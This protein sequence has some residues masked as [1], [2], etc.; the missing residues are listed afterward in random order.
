MIRRLRDSHFRIVMVLAAL[1]P[2]GYAA[3][4]SRR[5]PTRSAATAIPADPGGRVPAGAVFQLL[6]SPRID[7]R[8][9]APPGQGQ[10]D[11]LLI[12]P[13]A[14]PA[15]PDLL[16]YWSP[17]AGDGQTLPPDAMLIGALRGSR[18][19]VLPLPEPGMMQG[20]YL[21]L[22]SLVRDEILAAVR[23]TVSA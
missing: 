21:I 17:T 6:A 23:L 20:G 5:T 3:L 7:G 12:T 2:I 1:L 4:L 16:A 13:A 14:D 18:E 10:P 8:L 22:Y 19:Q 11:A 9:L 15:I